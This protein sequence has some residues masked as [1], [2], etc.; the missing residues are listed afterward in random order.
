MSTI[1][2]N[3]VAKS[4]FWKLLERIGVQLC[5]FVVLIVLARLLTPTEYGTIAIVNIL[6]S[7]AAALIQGGMNTALI[8]KKEIDELTINT[9]FYASTAVFVVFYI[10]LYSTSGFFASFFNQPILEQIIP[11]IALTLIVGAVNSIQLALLSRQMKF[12]QIFYCS[13]IPAIISGTVGIILANLGWGV[14]ALV[15]QQA[16]LHL[17]QMICMFIATHWFPSLRF[18]FKKLKEIWGFSINIMLS[19]LLTSIFLEI[20]SLVIGKFYTAAELSYFEKGRYLPQIIMTNIN[21]SILSVIFPVFSSMQDDIGKI[22]QYLRRCIKTSSYV[23]FPIMTLLAVAAEPII[24]FLLTEKW[25]EAV[26]FVQVFA[27]T[28]MIMPVHQ[29]NIE[30][31]KALGKG[32]IILKLD[33][34]RKIVELTT[35]LI[36]LRYGPLAIA[37]GAFIASIISIFINLNPNRK[38]ID[39]SYSE[40]FKDILPTTLITMAMG[41][42]VYPIHNLEFS[43]LITILIV[44]TVGSIVYILLSKIFKIESFEYA[45]QLISNRRKNNI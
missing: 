22:K 6:L 43:P 44:F 45:V 30:V 29:S 31:I 32:E 39:Y 37:I 5:S 24:V 35:L 12:K 27:L 11:I 25:I 20:R 40:Q 38:L 1:T 19:N 8:Q 16:T 2:R 41:M 36:A 33:I 42:A 13:L 17:T 23:T 18:S 26:P 10:V 34:L 4:L 14:W 21:S 15:A 7:V 9:V 28:Y 3:N